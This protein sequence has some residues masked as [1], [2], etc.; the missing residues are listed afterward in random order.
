MDDAGRR[1]WLGSV[2]WASF[3]TLPGRSA[4]AAESTEADAAVL[5]RQGG[6]GLVV[7]MRHALAPGTF[8]PPGFRPGECSTQ[9]NLSEEGREQARRIGAWF[10]ERRL[11]PTTVRS[12]EWCRCLDTARLAFSKVQPWSALNSAIGERGREG[13][14]NTAMRAELARLAGVNAPGFEVW[15]THQVNITALAGS[16]AGSGEA[17]LLRHAAASGLPMV[18]GGLQVG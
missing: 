1:R 4:R 12:S 6:R 16:Y 9:R 17:V 14:Q 15:V 10:R 11:E 18:L 2:L 7:V 5:L 13:S 8:D 3:A